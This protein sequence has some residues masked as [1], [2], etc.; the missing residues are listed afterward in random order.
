MINSLIDF[1]RNWILFF[2]VII[3]F[4]WSF[5]FFMLFKLFI[6]ETQGK[7]LEADIKEEKEGL[8][9]VNIT[10]FDVA[11]ISA[12]I[13]AIGLTFVYNFNQW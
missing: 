8:S 10:L 6:K 3:F 9:K 4:M 2:G 5:R 1:V 11:Y 13:I 12:F 7:Y